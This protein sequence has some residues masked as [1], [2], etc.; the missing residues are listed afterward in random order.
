[1]SEVD[2]GGDAEAWLA[3]LE[4]VE[5]LIGGRFG[6]AEPRRRVAGY[7]RELLAPWERQNGWTVAEHAGAVSPD[8]TQ[9]LVRTA[10]WSAAE[11]RDDLRGSV[12]AELG[13]PAGIRAVDDPGCITKGDRSAGVARHDTGT[14]GTIDTCQI[15]VFLSCLTPAG[16]RTL[17]DRELYPPHGWTGD[18]PRC[19]A[20]G[21]G[22]AVG[23]ATTPELARRLATRAVPAQ[24]P[25]SWVTADEASGQHRAVRRWRE[26]T[27]LPSLLATRRDN[28]LT[29]P[30]NRVADGPRPAR[31]G[32]PV[33]RGTPLGRR[34]RPRPAGLRRGLGAPRRPG[35]ARLVGV[36]AGPPQH[37]RR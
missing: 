16:D 14:T 4:R 22:D 35:R 15:G 11:V 6:R 31:P 32:P 36:A 23:F 26:K 1:V 5:A 17:I 30:G 13:D 28:M 24:V 3:E 9:R 2:D 19:P 10:R 34:R 20:A 8:G 25:F 37:H 29:L 33:P 21:I 18:R 27:G 7:L 12:V